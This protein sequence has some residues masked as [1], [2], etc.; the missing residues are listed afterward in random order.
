MKYKTYLKNRTLFEKRYLEDEHK[1]FLC[2]GLLVELLNS[3][4]NKALF[5][6]VYSY[7]RKMQGSMVLR[8]LDTKRFVTITG[9]NM[10]ALTS[11]DLT[12]SCFDTYGEVEYDRIIKFCKQKSNKK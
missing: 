12:R 1:R 5:F 8:C 2:K 11:L 3:I 9:Q 4:H 10:S 6:M 7:D